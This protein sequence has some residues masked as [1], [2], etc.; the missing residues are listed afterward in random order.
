[1]GCVSDKPNKDPLKNGKNYLEDE[2]QHPNNVHPVIG[3]AAEAA[4]KNEKDRE[5]HHEKEELRDS[6]K[7]AWNNQQFLSLPE[8]E[9]K[10]L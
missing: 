8:V 1:M 4:A 9:G 5:S 3:S 6:G 7:P 10:H 2:R